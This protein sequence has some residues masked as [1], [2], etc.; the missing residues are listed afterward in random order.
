MRAASVFSKVRVYVDLTGRSHHMETF[1]KT[2]ATWIASGGS[3]YLSTGVSFGYGS[4]A[5][6]P[7]F[8]TQPSIG[9]AP[10]C[11]TDLNVDIPQTACVIFNSRGVPV[12]SIGNPIVDTVYVTDGSVVYGIAVSASGM[13]RSWK[14]P[15]YSTAAWV[16]Q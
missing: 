6:A 14:T 16:Q 15:A 9:Q 7:P 12:D 10:L 4:L 2:T 1:D 5:T 11:K 8:T 13:I 3:T